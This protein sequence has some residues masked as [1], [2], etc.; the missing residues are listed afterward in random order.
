MSVE[1]IGII[2]YNDAARLT[3]SEY[4]IFSKLVQTEYLFLKSK[5]ELEAISEVEDML[6]MRTLEG[7]IREGHGGFK[8]FRLEDITMDEIVHT[9]NLDPKHE[10]E[11]SQQIIDDIKEFIQKNIDYETGKSKEK[12]ERFLNTKGEPLAGSLYLAEQKIKNPLHVLIGYY[13]GSIMDNFDWRMRVKKEY[14]IVMGG[15]YCCAVNTEVIKKLGWGLYALAN[16]ENYDNG[17]GLLS[18]YKDKSMIYQVLKKSKGIIDNLIV[19]SNNKI[20]NAYIRMLH[21]HGVSDDSAFI[22]AGIFFSDDAAHGLFLADATDTWDKFTPRIIYGGQD[23]LIGNIINDSVDLGLSEKAKIDFIYFAAIEK[24]REKGYPDSSQRYFLQKYNGISAVQNHKNFIDFLNNQESKFENT[25]HR[26]EKKYRYSNM[27]LGFKKVPS[28]FFY[29]NI[30]K[31]KVY[32]FRKQG[33][34]RKM[35]FDVG[36]NGCK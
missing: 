18:D 20:V 6:F 34:L 23:E 12:P 25:I 35:G 5:Y 3:R 30:L 16:T 29:H 2:P 24:F 15:G 32:D 4:K 19:D 10:K 31:Q 11:K 14:N 17:D 36:F 33:K 7:R 26:A 28:N 21:G 27:L 13:L 8:R 9:L 22:G 1:E